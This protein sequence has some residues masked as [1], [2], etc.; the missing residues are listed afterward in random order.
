MKKLFCLSACLAIATAFCDEQKNITP[1]PVSSDHNPRP[2]LQNSR[3]FNT[4]ISLEYITWK[5]GVPRLAF[6]RDGV[7]ITNT[8]PPQEIAIKKSGTIYLPSYHYSP[9][10]RAGVGFR[11]GPGK[12]Y[13]L[14]ARYLWL[15]TNPKKHVSQN[16][17]SGPF[18]P[19]NWLASST[20]TTSTY[21]SADANFSLHY[22]QPE[23]QAGYTF[24]VSRYLTLR[25]YMA[26][27]AYILKAD[28]VVK[29]AFID[30]KDVSTT[31]RRKSDSFSWSIG[32]KIGLDFSFLP[33]KHFGIF[34]NV[35]CTHQ[36]V[37]LNMTTKQ[38]NRQPATG[39]SLVIQRGKSDQNRSISLLGLEIGPTWDQWFFKNRY[40]LQLRVTW[41]TSTVSDT[42]LS[43]LNS[44]NTD[45]GIGS[46]FRG[47]N[48]RILNEF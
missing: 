4:L 40:H 29:Y 36:A 12:A 6:G 45:T 1:K 30:S 25:P 8:S 39:R 20:L 5:F 28:Y 27:T 14:W 21:Q 9:G 7:G 19:V 37:Q 44:N 22:Q 41:Q 2:A 32:P 48:F 23:I 35:N 34:C 38:T 10:Y 3:S 42:Q 15:Y 16:H 24:G 13:D 46:E 18:F 33:T 26:L 47:L 31:A 17:L 43:L 11:F